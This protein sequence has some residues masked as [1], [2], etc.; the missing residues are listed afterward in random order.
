MRQTH[1]MAR[2]PTLPA[3]TGMD[4][5]MTAY[6]GAVARAKAPS[7]PP[8]RGFSM[9]KGIEPLGHTSRNTNGRGPV[10]GCAIRWGNGKIETPDKPPHGLKWGPCVI[11]PPAGNLSPDVNVPLPSK[12][13][14]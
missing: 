7:P 5:N 12:M 10:L 14:P 2:A 13:K 11:G 1:A 8:V 6:Y 4:P 9:E 3:L